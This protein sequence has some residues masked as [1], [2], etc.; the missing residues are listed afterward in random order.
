MSEEIEQDEPPVYRES[1]AEEAARIENEVNL[2][3]MA[4]TPVVQQTQ[5]QVVAPSNFTVV[6]QQEMVIVFA[7]RI[8]P[9]KNTQNL[10]ESHK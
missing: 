7:L 4:T 9:L 10:I 6:T 8:T 3:T 5:Q 2:P 1:K